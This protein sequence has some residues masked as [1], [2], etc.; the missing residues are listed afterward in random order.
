M[1]RLWISWWRMPVPWN[2]GD[3][4]GDCRSSWAV[5]SSCGACAFGAAYLAGCGGA[6]NCLSGGG[7]GSAGPTVVLQRGQ[8]GQHPWQLVA[9]EQGG[10]LGLGLDGASQKNQYSGGL[11]FC[12]DPFAGFW[13]EAAGPEGSTFYYGPSPAS[14]KYAVF[15]AHGHAPVTVATRPIPQEDGLPSGRFF[16]S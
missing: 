11:G 3:I 14:A 6:P 8:L 10:L 12:S 1:S 15:T 2:G 9:W 16:V 13:L 4:A 5:A 7:G